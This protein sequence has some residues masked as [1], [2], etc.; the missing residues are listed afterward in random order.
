[1]V[2]DSPLVVGIGGTTRLNSSTEIV[3]H[4]ALGAA[5]RAGATIKV[6]NGVALR[7]LPIYEPE[8][9]ER[10]HVAHDLVEALRSA[11]GVVIA[12]PAYHG[13][14]SGMV[15]NALDYTEDLSGD[16]RP[17]LD[18][19]AV[20]CIATGAG[21]Q[22]VVTTLWAIRSVV[23]ALRGWPTPLGAVC[24]SEVNSIDASAGRVIDKKLVLQLDTVGSE[25]VRF[26]QL[27]RSGF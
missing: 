4:V 14:I 15:K 11:D 25:V 5:E 3:L 19:R 17:Y 7:Q 8:L 24:N 16:T 26:A 1:M 20:G 18:G 22:G 2:N 10:H 9:G 6:F 23:H 21:W 13:G 27:R 12:S